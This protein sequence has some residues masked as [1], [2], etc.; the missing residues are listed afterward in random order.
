[1]NAE[2][3]SGGNRTVGRVSTQIVQ[4]VQ[5]LHNRSIVVRHGSRK[6]DKEIA[7]MLAV[8]HL[9]NEYIMK[10]IIQTHGR[11]KKRD[12]IEKEVVETFDN[13][14]DA[15]SEGRLCE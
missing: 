8:I 2:H 13:M 1:M 15:A 10:L 6:M 14:F 12:E 3:V 7:Q 11:P 9:E 4:T 5:I